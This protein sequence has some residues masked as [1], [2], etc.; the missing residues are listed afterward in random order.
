MNQKAISPAEGPSDLSMRTGLPDEW[1]YL[2]KS[3]PR[4]GWQA[5][6][7]LGPLT[8]FWL[9]RHNGFREMGGVLDVALTKFREGEVEAEPFAR[10]FASNLQHFL[11]G[12][13]HH[14]IIEDN[15]YFPVFVEAEKRL[16]AGFELLENDH[17]W[18]DHRIGNMVESANAF[19]QS[20]GEGDR[21]VILKTAESFGMASDRLLGGLMRHLDDEEDLVVPLILDRGEEELGIS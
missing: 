3:H 17:E 11:T 13:H 20:L 6:H 5:H 15:H 14:H 10:H 4:E 19:F 21:D 7:N 2:L 16:L 9:A 8:E 1:L 12:L 18:L